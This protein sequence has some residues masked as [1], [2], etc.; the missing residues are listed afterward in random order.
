MIYA[1]IWIYVNR[2]ETEFIKGLHKPAKAHTCVFEAAKMKSV[3]CAVSLCPC[4]E[5]HQRMFFCSSKCVNMVFMIDSIV[6][7]VTGFVKR[8][9]VAAS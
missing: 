9:F 2:T 6:H 5:S 3:L 7:A 8:L 4:L 1:V